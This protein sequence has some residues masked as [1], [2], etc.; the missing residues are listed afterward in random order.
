[1]WEGIVLIFIGVLWIII[2]STSR[3]EIGKGDYE[4]SFNFNTR[5]YI[6]AAILIIIGIYRLIISV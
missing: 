1:M 3:R 2:I 6:Y 5:G 4:G